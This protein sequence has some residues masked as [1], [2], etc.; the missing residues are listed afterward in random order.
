M[1]SLVGVLE[2]SCKKADIYDVLNPNGPTLIDVRHEKSVAISKAFILPAYTDGGQYGYGDIVQINESELFC[3]SARFKNF[4]DFDPGANIVSSRSIDS[5]K[6]WS[7]PIALQENIGAIN[8]LAPS[9]IKISSS[10]LLIFFSMRRTMQQIEIMFKESNDGGRTWGEAKSVNKNDAFAYQV[11]NNARVRLIGNRLVM[12]VAETDDIFTNYDKQ[13]VFC[14]YSDN[15]GASWSRS[16][17][18]YYKTPLMEPGI[19]AISESNWLM[20]IRTRTGNVFFARSY[21]R[22]VNWTLYNSSI[23]S[24]ASPQTIFKLPKTDTL[25]MVWNC[26]TATSGVSGNDR[27][28][29]SLA[30]STNEGNTWQ[31]VADI[32]TSNLSDFSYASILADEKNI[33]V[34]YYKRDKRSLH[35]ASLMIATIK[36]SSL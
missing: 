30:I 35:A 8:T 10:K 29:L 21:D 22:G 28:P 36:R 4:Y 7:S 14:Y 26:T 24:P 23:N 12:P 34:S 2:V 5:G 16:K 32:E 6:T 13:K 18:I 20:N 15:M 27:S 19:T 3:V 11:L 17:S 9:L 25:L 31:W 33:Y 1:V